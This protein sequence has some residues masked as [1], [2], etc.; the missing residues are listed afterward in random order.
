M[1]KC[2]KKIFR[3]IGQIL[4]GI[5]TIATLMAGRVMAAGATAGNLVAVE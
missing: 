3:K 5:A 4:T 1:L 2:D